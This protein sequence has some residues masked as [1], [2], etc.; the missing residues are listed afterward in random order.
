MQTL[1][2]KKTTSFTSRLGAAPKVS[3]TTGQN[4]IVAILVAWNARYRMR[5][6]LSEMSDHM[7]D[8]IGLTRDATQ[9]EVAKPFWRA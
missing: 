6:A 8:D 2:Y 9:A 3:A 5:R 7:L 4:K 1:G